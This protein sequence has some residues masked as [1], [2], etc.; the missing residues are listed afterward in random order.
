VSVPEL[1]EVEWDKRVDDPHAGAIRRQVPMGDIGSMGR[2]VDKHVVP[3]LVS[4]GPRTSYLLIPFLSTVKG[5]IAL[6]DHSPIAEQLVVDDLPH[7]ELDRVRHALPPPSC[8]TP[9]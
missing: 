1:V 5:G 3:G 4:G 9:G 8:Q 7:R 2:A 6:D